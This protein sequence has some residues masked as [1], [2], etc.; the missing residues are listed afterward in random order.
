MKI[1]TLAALIL[2][3]AVPVAQALT[4]EALL[5]TLQ[6]TA[7]D[8]FWNEANPAN[9]LIKDRSTSTS[10]CSIASVGFGLSAI[11]IGID[12]GWVSREEGRQRILT[13]LQTLWNGPQGT[14]ASGMIGYQGLFYHFLDMNTA[15]R[16]WNCE[17]S[18]ID[19]AL[20]FAGIMD[21]RQYFDTVDPLDADLRDLADAITQRA[22]W[23]WARASGVGIRMGWQ[24][25]SGF[26]GFGTWVGYNEATILYIIALGSPTHPVLSSTWYTWTSGYLWNTHYGYTYV[27]F[28]PLFGHQ[29]SHCWIDFRYIQDA[30]MRFRDSTYFENSRLATYAARAYCIDNP[31]GWTGYS[32]LVWGLTA[33]DGPSGYAARGAPPGQNDDGT[34]APTAAAGS[35]AFAPEIVI[36]T[37]HHYYDTYHDQLWSTYGFKDAFN[38]TQNWWDTDY[39]GIDE[40]PIILMIENYRTGG[41]WQRMMDHPDIQRGLEVAGFETITGVAAEPAQPVTTI[42][43][44]SSSPNPFTGSTLIVYRLARAGQASLD[45]Y[46]VRGRR[47]GRLVDGVQSAGLHEATLDGANLP[48]GVYF[49][50][51]AAN[52]QQVWRRCT[53]IR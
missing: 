41:I 30:Y 27:Q 6:H 29:Y 39:I 24:P 9:G 16:T 33:C 43:L 5:D 11:C 17:L 40:G 46:D 23:E 51:L 44:S 25:G 42:S 49:Y 26:D 28:P 8:F 21:A 22:D 20:L 15:T 14:A 13:T 48:S 3:A 52:G 12:H 45:V 2:L 4:T 47:V 7:F 1:L 35:I 37:L 31:L 10:P 18:T 53:L 34:V 32:D 19:T 36:P 50:R 38:L